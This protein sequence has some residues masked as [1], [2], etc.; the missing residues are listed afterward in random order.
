[1]IN[2]EEEIWRAHPDFEKLEVST[3]GRVRSIKGHYYKSWLSNGGYSQ[4]GFRINGKKINKLVHRL[5]A[6]TFIPNLNGFPEVNH[7]DCNRI[8]NNVDN[9][10]WCT[11]EENIAYRDKCGH[12]AKNNAPKLPVFAVNLKTL[13]V[14]RFPSQNEAGRKLGVDPSSIGR[15]L[16]GK[17]KQAGGYWFVSDDDNASDTIEQKLHEIKKLED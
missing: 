17:Q 13:E 14:S 1:M 3:F 12:T 8:N 7:K 6:E 9:L 15:T 4:V 5:V 10:E 2:N 11:H 16:E